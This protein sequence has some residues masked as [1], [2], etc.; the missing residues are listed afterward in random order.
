MARK[1]H[2]TT[3][4]KKGK[5]KKK[6]LVDFYGFWERSS[7]QSTELLCSC[8][9]ETFWMGG[10][11]K[12]SLWSITVGGGTTFT[13]ILLTGGHVHRHSGRLALIYMT[14]NLN[15]TKTRVK[16][17]VSLHP[18]TIYTRARLPLRR[19]FAKGIHLHVYVE[20]IFFSFRR[21]ATALM[22]SIVLFGVVISSRMIST[23]FVS[24][25]TLYRW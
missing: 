10:K 8:S 12:G 16:F 5:R 21:A 9:E 19:T 23:S 7:I 2:F 17:V 22:G 4:F 3:I 11:K 20:N 15:C 6:G 14:E 1:F 13:W 18:L 25:R 24:T